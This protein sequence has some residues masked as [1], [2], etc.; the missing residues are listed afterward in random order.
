MK[1]LGLINY[2]GDCLKAIIENNEILI[3]DQYG[4]IVQKFDVPQF[5]GFIDGL[6]NVIDSKGKSWNYPGES[7]D[8]KP[9]Y[10]MIYH[11]VKD[12]GPDKT[13]HDNVKDELINLLESQV[14]DLTMM[15]KIELG[16][17]VIREIIRLKN[18][19]RG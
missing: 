8:A 18:I 6:I 11:F 3:S 1:K 12:L 15:S 2:E 14:M 10:S 13:K 5:Y 19:I 7:K 16:D 9:S 17:D 4:E